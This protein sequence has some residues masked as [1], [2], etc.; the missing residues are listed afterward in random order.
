M[1]RYRSLL[2]LAL[3]LGLIVG[4]KSEGERRLIGTWENDRNVDWSGF[5]PGANAPAAGV[6]KTSKRHKAIKAFTKAMQHWAKSMGPYTSITF[7]RNGTYR[8]SFKTGART[9]NKEGR[10]EVIQPGE[11]EIKVRMIPGGG[12]GSHS[13]DVT[14]RFI[15][16]DTMMYPGLGGHKTRMKR[17]K[18]A[19]EAGKTG[20]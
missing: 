12:D 2:G 18:Q 11:Q 13:T 19:P 9:H 3:L 20:S 4:C 17:Q 15:D 8:E 5:P 16:Q 14:I 6:T 10:W 1:K 7:E